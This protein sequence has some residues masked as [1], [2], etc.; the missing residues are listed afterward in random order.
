[1]EIELKYK[2]VMAEN[3]LTIKDLPEDAQT[4]IT[5]INKALNGVKMLSGKSLSN[6]TIKKI[7]A[8]DKWVTYEIYD[9]LHDT[10][11][12]EDEIPHDAEEVIDEIKETESDDKD[13][14]KPTENTNDQLTQQGL[15]IDTDLDKAF[16]NGIKEISL[17]ELKT[18][19][20][21]AHNIIF[22]SYDESGDNGIETSNYSLLETDN[23]IFTL[24]KK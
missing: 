4:G 2:E 15:R 14:Q 22:D 16:K 17:N 19:S 9:M 11:K 7:K 20:K 18:I 1:M 21:T 13:E 5:E 8:M 10:D 12:N 23:E 24:T 6:A 3:N